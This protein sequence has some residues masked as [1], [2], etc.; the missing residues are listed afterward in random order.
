VLYLDAANYQSY[1]S[2]SIVWN[3]LTSNFTGS[4]INGAAYRATNVGCINFDGTNDYAILPSNPSLNFTGNFC[5]DLW[6][7]PFVVTSSPHIIYA[8]VPDFTIQFSNLN[9]D[10]LIVYESGPTRIIG[11]ISTNQWTNVIITRTGTSVTAYR[12]AVIANTWTSSAQYYFNRSLFA[13]RTS[14]ALYFNGN[15][16][17]LKLYNRNLSFA[18]VVQN[19]NATKTRFGL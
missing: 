15:I 14:P 19:Y 11:S 17:S 10:Q 12:N 3:D 8:Q 5:F 18:E 4:L 13:G 7:N 6:F 1:T 16:S 2:G 9:S